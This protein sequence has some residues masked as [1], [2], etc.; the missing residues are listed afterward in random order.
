[1]STLLYLPRVMTRW[2]TDGIFRRIFK[3]A[4]LML[5][6]RVATGVFSLGT[7][8]LA[9]HGLGVEQFGILIL[10]Q[11]YVLAITALTTFQSWQAV[12]RYGATCLE[13]N[14]IPALQSLVKFTTLLD[15]AGV[16]LGS[17]VGYFAAPY[18]GP[19]VGWNEEVISYAQPFSFLVLFTIVA[20][21]TG[22]LRLYDRFDLLALHTV[23]TPALRFVG[24]GIATLI[25]APFWAFLL[26]YFVA[27]AIGGVVL[28]YLGWREIYR[29]GGLKGVSF[30][31]SGLTVPHGGIWKFSI[32]SNLHASLQVVTAHMS[33]FLVGIVAGPAAAGL[34]RIGRDV[35][36]AL[37]K[38]AELLNQSIYPEFARLGT[39]GGWDKFA[40]LIL[41]SGALAGGAGALLL[42]L[43]FAFGEPFL[44]F[45]F[46]APF[47]DA[48]LAL[49]LLVASAVITIAGFSMDPAL[50]AMGR[51]SIPLR[52]DVVS[53]LI[54]FVPLLVVLT[55]LYGPTGAAIAT[56]V[57]AAFTFGAMAIFTAAQLRQRVVKQRA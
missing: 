17:F 57:S 22:L 38:P 1:M 18:V 26:S 2:F 44:V 56:L 46:G 35:A 55:R 49:A 21:P 33:T 3:N 30:S 34:F 27:G 13:N 24:V 14:N 52:I 4:G 39:K 20:T 8:S 10:I 51:P 32:L 50:Y 31:C 19:Y 28:L 43:T 15:V 45:F 48:Y 6:G 42:G 47:A 23:V 16:V 41:R 54:I 36:T 29:D 9:A 12:I 11:T 5:T 53:I 40:Y 25:S 37:T 7:L